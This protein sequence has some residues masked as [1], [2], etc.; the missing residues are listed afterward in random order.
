MSSKMTTAT[1]PVYPGIQFLGDLTVA[2]EGPKIAA[3]QRLATYVVSD[4][5]QALLVEHV[6]WTG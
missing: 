3:G 4:R 5:R 2:P 6:I 1:C